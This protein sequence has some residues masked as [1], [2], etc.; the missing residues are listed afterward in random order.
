VEEVRIQVKRVRA[1]AAPLPLPRYMT[2]GAAGM[3]LYADVDSAVTLAPFQRKLIPT[4]IAVALPPGFEAQVRPRS[5][6]ALKSGLTLLNSPGTIDCDYRGEIQLIAI[7][8]GSEPVAIERGQRIAQ[9]VIQRVLRAAWQEV[10][11]LPGSERQTGGFG[12][13]DEI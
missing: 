4:G 5:G 13:T 11:D 6:L 3:D 9:L 12:H 2:A 1:D 8:M 7:N 10:E